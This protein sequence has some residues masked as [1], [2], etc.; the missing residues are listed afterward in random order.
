MSPR[1]RLIAFVAAAVAGAGALHLGWS[2]VLAAIVARGYQHRAPNITTIEGP[3]RF[4]LLGRFIA[5]EAAAAQARPFLAFVGSSFT[6]GYPWRESAIFSYRYAERHPQ[7]KVVNLS[8]L[9]ADTTSL[10][11]WIFCSAKV[12][13]VR[14]DTTF[15][16]IPVVNEVNS[17]TD[18][19]RRRL[20]M[21]GM[22]RFDACD[23]D[24][25]GPRYLGYFLRYPYGVGWLAGLRDPDAYDKPDQMPSVVVIPENYFAGASDFAAVERLYAARV[26]AMLLTA[27]AVSRRVVAYP[28]PILLTAA[29]AAGADA[30]ALR[31]QLDAALAACRAVPGV[32]C[33]DPAFLYDRPADFY[34]HTHLNQRGHAEMADWLDQ[35]AATP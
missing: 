2:G 31:A 30:Q 1:A 6:Y 13:G 28:A 4:A 19:R 23:L 33:L 20:V 24:P 18:Y 3:E 9:S 16:E 15:V 22:Q 14:F 11:D 29:R 27:R 17:L 35:H 8:M 32:T 10:N 12:N 21:P 7:A 25:Q 26:S 34:N 5:H